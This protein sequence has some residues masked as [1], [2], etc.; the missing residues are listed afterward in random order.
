M[1]LRFKIATTAV[2]ALLVISLSINIVSAVNQSAIPGSDQDPIV[3]KSYVDAAFK[4]LSNQIQM[5]IEQN[6]V[7]KS[8]NTQLT[9]DLAN[10]QTTIKKLQDEINTLKSTVASASSSTSTG[11]GTGEAQAPAAQTP[12]DQKPAASLGKGVINTAVLNLRA[13]PNTTSSILGK[14]VKNDT[15]TVVSKSDGWY[16]ITTSKGK[17]GYV[18]A[19]F[20]TMK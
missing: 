7:L 18:M 5:L 20:V 13:K 12:S 3:S 10:Q 8:Q 6:D 4:E 17:T 16:K 15:V 9:A 19:T 11:G 2:I 1:K 14:L